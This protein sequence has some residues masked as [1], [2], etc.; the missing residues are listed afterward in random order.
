MKRL[1]VLFLL[2]LFVCFE[3]F[4]KSIEIVYGDF[5]VSVSPNSDEVKAH[6]VFKNISSDEIKVKLKL[7]LAEATEGLDVS[8]CWGPICYPPM[9]VN[10]LWEPDDVIT[11]KPGEICGSNEFYLTFS[12]NG[13]EGVAIVNAVLYVAD[14]PEDSVHI[15]FRLSSTISSVTEM[16]NIPHFN[17][18]SINKAVDLSKFGFTPNPIYIYSIK[19][20]FLHSQVYNSGSI[21][22]SFLPNG[23]YMIQQFKPQ[24]KFIFINKN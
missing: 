9:A 8:F 12:P 14:N 24:Y 3:T 23:I 4:S 13:Y 19:G 18:I 22:L 6:C 21:E 2:F 1:V 15:S 11:L 7:L 5:E 20:K 16:F 17:L 10:E